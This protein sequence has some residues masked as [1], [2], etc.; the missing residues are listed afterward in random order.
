MFQSR[1][2]QALF[3]IKE[4]H[5]AQEIVEMVGYANISCVFNLAKYHNLKVAKAHGKLHEEMRKYKAEGH[6][7]QEVADKF[8]VSQNTAQNVCKGICPQIRLPKPPRGEVHNC[9][10]C[11]KETDRPKYCSD[12]CR[13][14]ASNAFWN[15]KRRIR[16]KDATVDKDITLHDLFIRDKGRCHICGGACDWDDKSHNGNTFVFGAM[17]PTVDHVIA[18]S[19]GGE[20]SWENVRLAHK[21]CNSAKGARQ[22]NTEELE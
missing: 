15:H 1:A 9:P 21:G 18:L 13:M 3:L 10:M 11:G 22:L 12:K 17:Y 7:M 20:H 8:G 14:K 2:E 4:G 16:I 6:S 19:N 5:T